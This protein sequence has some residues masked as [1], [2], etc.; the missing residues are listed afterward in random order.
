MNHLEELRKT[1]KIK[2]EV[3]AGSHAYGTNVETSDE[4]IRGIFVP[5]AHEYISIKEPPAQIN[6]QKNDVVFYS[7]KR[8]FELI[9]TANPNLIELL[10]IPSD[11][12]IKQDSILDPL[13]QNKELFITK[14]A[15]MSHSCYAKAQIKKA[16]GCNKRV[17]NPQ[18]KEKPH[19]SEFCFV[20]PRQKHKDA[21]IARPIPIKELEI[22]LSNFHV[23]KL[24]QSHNTFRMY[25]Y[26]DQE[27]RQGVF[28]NGDIVC[29][30]IP[31]DD[32]DA[33]FYGMLIYNKE[34]YEKAVSEWHNYWDWFNNR[35][36]S[37]WIDQENGKLD[38][39]G[40]N[41]MHCYRLLLSSKNIL[42]NHE[43]IVRFDGEERNKLLAIRNGEWD[44]EELLLETDDLM[45]E[46]DELYKKTDLPDQVDH[47]KADD[48]FKAIYENLYQDKLRQVRELI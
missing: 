33:R 40:K 13:F 8:F 24:E 27:N 12:I 46:I 17:N 1:S 32:E 7:I 37:R 36:E 18:P 19:R 30:S 48:I 23:A 34:N 41:M 6:D 11:C 2:F 29:Q 9:N 16:K 44:Y 4:D 25:D 43:P 10:W 26:S 5:D 39:D 14:K 38:Y 15:Y 42:K 45:A 3:I 31:L 21:P 20:I 47:K 35:N 22:D 28:K